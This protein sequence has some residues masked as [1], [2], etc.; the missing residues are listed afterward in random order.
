MQSLNRHSVYRVST[1]LGIGSEF[2]LE[3]FMRNINITNITALT[4]TALKAGDDLFDSCT[5]LQ[6]EFKGCDK[7]QVHSTLLPMVVAYYVA[8]GLKAGKPILLT[9][10][11]QGSG[12]LVMQGDASPVSAATKRLNKL[13]AVITATVQDKTEIDVPADILEAAAKLWALCAEYKLA[14]KICASAIATAKAK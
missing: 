7:A 8:K 3:Y 5:E 10:K 11:E 14:N 2:Y 4:T 9:V 13:V 1:F 6:A 12:R